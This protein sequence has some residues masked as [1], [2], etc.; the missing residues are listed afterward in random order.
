M[1][2]WTA[3]NVYYARIHIAQARKSRTCSGACRHA[4]CSAFH[5]YVQQPQREIP[6]LRKCPY[7]GGVRTVQSQ[8]PLHVV[9]RRCTLLAALWAAHELLVSPLAAT[10]HACMRACVSSCEL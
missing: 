7:K 6:H 3:C 5:M 1:G 2:P 8:T 4:V 10:R 9:A